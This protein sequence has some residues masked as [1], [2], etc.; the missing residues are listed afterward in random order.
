MP[1]EAGKAAARAEVRQKMAG[2]TIE[3]VAD[4]VKVDPQTFGDFLAG[5]RRSRSR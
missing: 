1:T 4:L 3:Q 5:R 2:R